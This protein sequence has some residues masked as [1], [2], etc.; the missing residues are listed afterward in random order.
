[1]N[2]Q[3][4][5]R[6]NP[7]MLT[8]PGEVGEVRFRKVVEVEKIKRDRNDIFLL[9]PDWRGFRPLMINQAMR[10]VP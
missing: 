7:L 1:M 6:L 9:A 5:P 3:A 8:V 10:R 4:A 2:R